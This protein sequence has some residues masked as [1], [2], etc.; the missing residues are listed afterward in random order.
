MKILLRFTLRAVGGPRALYRDDQG[1]ETLLV[2][3]PGGTE[4]SEQIRTM[5]LDAK[6]GMPISH[7]TEL[8]LFA[9]SRAQL[10]QEV[11]EP[12]LKRNAI[13]ICDRFTDSTIAYQGYG[14]GIDFAL[15]DKLNSIATGGL[16]PQMTVLFDLDS[17]EG[18]ARLHPGGH[19]RLEREALDFHLRVRAGY[20]TLAKAD[21]ERWRVLDAG[22]P[23]SVVQDE[24]G[25]ILIEF[26]GKKYNLSGLLEKSLN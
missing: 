10:V 25:K 23:F 16:K 3:E 21:L 11:I 18:L 17:S 4:L 24:L 20:L 14:R 19:D 15:I 1:I 6:R 26:A 7:A 2:R 22:K 13:V 5:L 12:A 8:L 9:A